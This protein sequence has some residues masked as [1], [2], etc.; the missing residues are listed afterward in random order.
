MCILNAASGEL[1]LDQTRFQEA[2][3]KFDRAIELEKK[4]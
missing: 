2:V 4:K 3:E 1:L